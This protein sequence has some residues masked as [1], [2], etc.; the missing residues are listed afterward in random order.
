M[1]YNIWNEIKVHWLKVGVFLDHL[2]EN[3]VRFWSLDS[4]RRKRFVSVC[5]QREG[6]REE[7]EREGGY[8]YECLANWGEAS[9]RAA[10]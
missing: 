10:G 3:L 7:A 6:S 8:D 4:F 1:E 5:W 9:G 2:L